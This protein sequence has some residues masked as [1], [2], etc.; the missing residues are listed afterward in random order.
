[1]KKVMN[2]GIAAMLALLASGVQAKVSEEEAKRLD[3]D[4]TPYGAE[5]AANADGSIPEWTG[6]MLGAPEALNYGGD[7]TPLPNPY[8]DEKP[9]FTV[10]ASNVAEYA[11]FLTEGQK[12]L[13]KK[14]PD[15][16]KM[17]IYP[18]HRDEAYSDKMMLRVRFNATNT[19]LSDTGEEAKSWTG[20]PAFPIPQSALEV[21]WNHWGFVNPVWDGT[22]DSVAVFANGSR[23]LVS[24]YT[25]TAFPS[26][27]DSNKVGDTEAEIG[28]YLFRSLSIQTFPASEKG[29]MNLVH[30]PVDYLANKRNA[31]TYIPG[32][33]RVRQA[34]SLGFDTPIGPG[35]L[36][37]ADEAEGF[38]GSFTARYTWALRDKMEIYV[39]AHSYK[40]DDFSVDYDEL[41]H[42][43]HA[44]PEYM[45]YEKR[46][47]WVVEATLKPGQR[48]LYAKRVFYLDEDTWSIA[49]VDTYDGRGELFRVALNN[50]LYHFALQGFQRRAALYHDLASGHYV[51]RS[52]VNAQ[53]EPIVNAEP[54]G[55]EFFSPS[56]LRRM[57]RR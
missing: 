25:R 35:G 41:L 42:V 36:M 49:I 10:S 21:M 29:K 22:V 3:T 23:N 45:R 16:F 28:K 15:T 52:L 11:Q 8:A 56:N 4:L 30:D 46:R 13:F 48:H 53:S 43:G 9:L 5:R 37:T 2:L 14:Y 6:T 7:G 27:F 32:T 44:N 20:G 33:R 51:A 31:W 57:G 34:P 17:N 26:I 54:W 50:N 18:T 19:E 40:F 12:A 38:N 1:M 24:T 47:V 55:D 39:P